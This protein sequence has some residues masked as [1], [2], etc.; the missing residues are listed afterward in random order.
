M[1]DDPD[2]GMR[3]VSCQTDAERDREQALREAIEMAAIAF[4]NIMRVARGAG[5]PHRLVHD[6]VDMVGA[7]N[8]Y[9]ELA[10]H[11][12]GEH[13][14]YEIR[15]LLWARSC[16]REWSDGIDEMS[17]GALQV[18]ASRLIGQ[19][20]QETRG[21]HELISGLTVIEKIRAA[22]RRASGR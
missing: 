3:L 21:E 17:R 4:A 8:A 2:K 14:A 16:D 13:V 15:H 9:F 7:F 10:G 11:Y 1:S 22:N 5:K 6:A 20:T 12:P 18:V 19:L